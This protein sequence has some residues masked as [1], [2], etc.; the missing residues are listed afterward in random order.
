MVVLIKTQ[1]LLM[2]LAESKE[3]VM[4]MDQVDWFFAGFIFVVWVGVAVTI[5]TIWGKDEDTN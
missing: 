5:L 1:I 3:T 4:W 2:L